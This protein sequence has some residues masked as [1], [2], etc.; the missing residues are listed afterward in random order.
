[1]DYSRFEFVF[2]HEPAGLSGL[3]YISGQSSGLS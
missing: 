2:L 3:V 1:M